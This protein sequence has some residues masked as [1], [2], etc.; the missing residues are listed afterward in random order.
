MWWAYTDKATKR[1][2][3]QEIYIKLYTVFKEEK[4]ANEGDG[5]AVLLIIIVMS[6][7]N[8]NA[9][10]RDYHA[11]FSLSYIIGCELIESEKERDS[12]VTCNA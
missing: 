9:N 4:N 3:R 8:N 11:I 5:I 2:N 12:Y 1:D 7:S 6:G 10:D